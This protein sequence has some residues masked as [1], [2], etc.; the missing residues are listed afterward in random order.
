MWQA[1]RGRSGCEF[2][3]GVRRTLHSGVCSGQR[4]PGLT[5]RCRRRAGGETRAERPN[6][7]GVFCGTGTSLVRKRL[8]IAKSSIKRLFR[9]EPPGRIEAKF[10]IIASRGRGSWASYTPNSPLSSR[11]R[12]RKAHSCSGCTWARDNKLD[13]HR[14]RFP[15]EKQRPWLPREVGIQKWTHWEARSPRGGHHPAPMSVE[16]A[17]TRRCPS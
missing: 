6:L 14:G 17:P 5:P 16:W 10:M 8:R 11:H 12:P 1:A 4:R 9:G 15:R 2:A 13:L 3:N 7:G